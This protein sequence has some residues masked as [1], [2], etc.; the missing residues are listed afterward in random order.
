M[1]RLTIAERLKSIWDARTTL[2]LTLD[3]VLKPVP[4]QRDDYF[5]YRSWVFQDGSRLYTLGRGLGHKVRT[6]TP[7]ENAQYLAQ[8]KRRLL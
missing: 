6:M 8:R 5:G 4:K 7:E 3:K 2:G 1:E